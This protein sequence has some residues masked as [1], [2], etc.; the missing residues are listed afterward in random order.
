MTT[1]EMTTTTSLTKHHAQIKSKLLR[2]ARQKTHQALSLAVHGA[3]E[4]GAGERGGLAFVGDAEA[5]KQGVGFIAG[6]H[7]IL[8]PQVRDA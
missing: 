5:G 2:F 7:V 1:H 6:E 4:R 3:R 8:R